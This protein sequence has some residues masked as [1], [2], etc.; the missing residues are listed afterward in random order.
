MQFLGRCMRSGNKSE[1]ATSS[2]DKQSSFGKR[3]ILPATCEF[4]QVVCVAALR[5]IIL[6]CVYGPTLV[7]P[8]HYSDLQFKQT[9]EKYT[10]SNCHIVFLLLRVSWFR[11]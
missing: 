3:R 7:Y 5:E 8:Q 9:S 6:L 1:L 10:Q 4:A 2:K 11:N